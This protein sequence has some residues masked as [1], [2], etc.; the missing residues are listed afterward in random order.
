M[1][2]LQLPVHQDEIKSSVAKDDKESNTRIEEMAWAILA[3]EI[4]EA[5]FFKC[6]QVTT[7]L[8]RLRFPKDCTVKCVK[9]L[10]ESHRHIAVNV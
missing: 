9:R 2:S 7:R 4:S 6:L 5:I 10:H 8:R 3:T 1:K